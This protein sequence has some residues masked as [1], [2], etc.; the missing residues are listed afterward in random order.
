M[1]Q[2]AEKAR[3]ALREA[4]HLMGHGVLDL[5]YPPHCLICERQRRPYLCEECA[6]RFLPVPEPV[7]RVCGRPV[8]GG[9]CRSCAVQG[10]GGW[11][12]ASARAAAVYEGPLRHAI[13]RLKYAHQEV[14]GEPLGIYLANRLI[15]DALLPP[16]AGIDLVVPVPIHSRR[17]RERG[18]NQ[19]ALLAAPVAAMLGVSFLLDGARRVRSTPPQVGLSPEARRRNLDGAFAAADAERI[20]GR[21]VLLIDDVFTTGATT[22][23]CARA[24]MEVGA[25]TV[26]VAVLAAGE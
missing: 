26:Y 8:D 21:R 17:A 4:A 25:T 6:G 11:A 20:A 12:F 5:I 9:A 23:A 3:A 10:P 18:F 14:L 19:S 2:G 15:V 22:H 1:F 7:C 13:H 24:L 16:A